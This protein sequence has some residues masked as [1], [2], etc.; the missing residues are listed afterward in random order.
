[1]NSRTTLECGGRSKRS[2]C[3][4]ASARPENP[5]VLVTGAVGGLGRKDAAPTG[6]F[7]AIDSHPFPRN[8]T[9]TQRASGADD[10][11][12]VPG[13]GTTARLRRG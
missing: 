6:R 10:I 4:F 3:P 11:A 8:E 12:L 7:G 9:P 2:T 5:C 13:I 1:M